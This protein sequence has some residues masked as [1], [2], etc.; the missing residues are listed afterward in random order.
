[1]L[2][3]QGILM[4]KTISNLEPFSLHTFRLVACTVKGCG[5][6]RLVS[7]RTLEAPPSGF[8]VMEAKVHDSRTI[9]VKWTPPDTPNGL[10]YYDIHL[11]GLFYIDTGKKK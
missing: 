3:Y 7:R 6:S 8:V 1:M 5:S 9:I 2:I 4:T 11:D 10:L